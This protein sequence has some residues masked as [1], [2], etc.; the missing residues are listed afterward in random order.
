MAR[1]RLQS[2]LLLALALTTIAALAGCASSGISTRRPTSQYTPMTVTGTFQ[3]GF[4]ISCF[5]PDTSPGQ[6]WWLETNDDFRRRYLALTIQ[7][8]P[9]G[10]PGSR[11]P[12]IVVVTIHGQCSPLG[13]YGHLGFYPHEFFVDQLLEMRLASSAASRPTDDPVISLWDRGVYLAGVKE[14]PLFVAWTDGTVVTRIRLDG[15]VDLNP[16]WLDKS[17]P[18]QLGTIKPEQLKQL[19]HRIDRAGF[20][21]PALERGR[22]VPDG[23]EQILPRLVVMRG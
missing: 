10:P 15:S 16:H 9:D 23:P 13:H 21:T 2:L 4:E 20:F 1:S 11:H 3:D 6:S 22:I 19:L 7:A 8:D 17:S 14:S 18:L 5:T 12:P